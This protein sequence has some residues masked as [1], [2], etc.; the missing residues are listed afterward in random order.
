MV[1][2]FRNKTSSIK[3]RPLKSRKLD[4]FRINPAAIIRNGV[5]RLVRHGFLASIADKPEDNPNR[6]IANGFSVHWSPTRFNDNDIHVGI[7]VSVKTVSK[8]ATKRNLARRR[9]RAL[10]NS[11]I[12]KYKISGFD[13]VFTARSTILDIPYEKLENELKR[14][15]QYVERKV[16]ISRIE[17]KMASIIRN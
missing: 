5:R 3:I 8:L 2:F 1:H 17:S 15:M 12:R 13:F 7:T 10:I 14:T 9:L 4:F 6:F 11:S 16:R